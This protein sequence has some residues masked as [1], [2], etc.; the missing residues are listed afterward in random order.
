M[1]TT[2]HRHHITDRTAPGGPY[3][4]PSWTKALSVPEHVRLHVCLRLLGLEFPAT[5]DLQ[6]HRCERL[7]VTA[8]LCPR[9]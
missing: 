2:H 3:I 8:L 5:D 1:T 7:L 4:D 9:G 6:A